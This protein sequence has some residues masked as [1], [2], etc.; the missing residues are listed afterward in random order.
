ML[1]RVKVAA[2]QVSPVFMDKEASIDKACR[3]IEEAGR[4]GAKLVVFSETFIPGYP[5]WRG[6]QPVS[7]WSELMV[8]YQK[9]AVVIPS[10]DTEVLGDAARRADAVA[11]VGCTELGGYRGSGTLY[12][13]VL[14]I[15]ND[16]KVLGRHRKMMPTHA[17][18]TVWGMG[19]VSD[20]RT[21]DTPLGTIGGLVCYEHHMSLLKAAMAV[22]G[23]E[24]HC[25]LWDGW[26]VMPRHPGA[27]RR[28]R[29]GEDPRLCDID[30][31]VK[32]YAFETQT[33]VVSSGQY[34]QD[35]AM[36]EECQGFNIAA[37]G[38]FIV[39]PAGVPLVGPVFDREE[40]LYAELDADD[41]RHTKAYV[42]A[43]GH[44]ARWDVLGLDLKGEP[45]V[46]LRTMRRQRPAR[47]R[48]KVVAEKHGVDLDRLEAILGELD[49][50]G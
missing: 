8:E 35:D 33:F 41:R 18:R 49:E 48:L 37:G 4:A 46:P 6:V 5:F 29:E 22:L 7:R 3:T 47:E 36:P 26:W 25:A 15:G 38:S 27:K 45:Q 34:I 16:G 1:D 44:Y 42:D 24:I 14:F 17:E 40:I 21:F 20:V 19:D 30:Y 10:G 11:V 43:L 28:Y 2:A 12:N 23:E 9:N 32:E 39:N 50:S 13:T 31:A